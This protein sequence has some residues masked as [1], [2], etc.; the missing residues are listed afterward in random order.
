LLRNTTNELGVVTTVTLFRCNN[1]SDPNCGSSTAVASVS[2]DS[3]GNYG[4]ARQPPGRYFI[5][6][7]LPGGYGVSCGANA[8][9]RSPV[10]DHT[11]F[12]D[13]LTLNIGLYKFVQLGDYVWDDV[14]RNG[15]QGDNEQGVANV[16]VMLVCNG[17]AVANTT[18]DSTGHYLF[19][20]VPPGNCTI[21]FQTPADNLRNFTRPY[22]GSSAQASAL[23][24]D[25]FTSNNMGLGCTLPFLV[26]AEQSSLDIDAGLLPPPESC[27]DY[28]GISDCMWDYILLPYAVN[29]M[30]ERLERSYAVL[31]WIHNNLPAFDQLPASIDADKIGAMA[32]INRM[33][34]ENCGLE[35]FCQITSTF[36]S[37]LDTVIVKS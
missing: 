22:A 37:R 1:P 20:Q 19:N 21:C 10:Y 24:S 7:N 33:F 35:Q 23:D 27:K 14:D 29:D 17:V 18:T 6:I 13:T 3:N 15:I 36:L 28:L 31:E 30:I 26:L 8:Q 2:T 5:T 11:G 4:F 9:G 32:E 12:V 16:T 25:V 34:L